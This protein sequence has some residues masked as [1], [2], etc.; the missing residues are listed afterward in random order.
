MCFLRRTS[1]SVALPGTDIELPQLDVAAGE[2]EQGDHDERIFVP[3]VTDCWGECK[4]CYYCI[5]DELAQHAQRDAKS[6]DKWTCLRCGGGVTR[7]KRLGA[8]PGALQQPSESETESSSDVDSGGIE[9]SHDSGIDSETER[10][11]QSWQDVGL[12]SS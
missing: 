11:G 8:A 5:A 6:E 1:A 2:E 10:L 7:A 4:Y 9:S 12:D 3:A